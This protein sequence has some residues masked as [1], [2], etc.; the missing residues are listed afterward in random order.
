MTYKE[1]YLVQLWEES[2]P[3]IKGSG[4]IAL[5]R[6]LS[7]E[8]CDNFEEVMV[9]ELRRFNGSNIDELSYSSV[10]FGL[11]TALNSLYNR[12]GTQVFKSR[13]TEGEK[14]LPINGLIWMGQFREM[15]ERI[16]EKVNQGFNCIKLKIGGIDLSEEI[17]LLRWLRQN[18][19]DRQLTLR[20]DANGSFSRVPYDKALQSLEHLSKFDIHSIEQPFVPSDIELTRKICAEDI[21]PVALD[22]QLI[23]IKSETEK[24][25]LLEY[26]K[27]QYIILKPSLCGG[28][29]EA[30]RWI[31]IAVNKNIGWWITSALESAIGL[32][33]IC[34]WTAALGVDIPQGL[35]T[36]ELY[37][38]DFPSPIKRKG[39]WLSFDSD[40]RKWEL[41]ETIRWIDVQP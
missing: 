9:E 5:F 17:E 31:D 23:G 32:N 18:F 27:P 2:M 29:T 10:R 30:K 35:G 13:F 16:S 7:A 15:R 24:T 1:T 39:E 25:E 11:E 8:S 12:G 41:P 22:E 36:G 4:E 3:D 21:I 26:L 33:A 34:Q 6:G 37:T 19:S 38:N 20:L 14:V 40:I 28:F